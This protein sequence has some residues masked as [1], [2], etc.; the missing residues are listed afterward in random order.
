[1]RQAPAL[2]LLVGLAG[3]PPGV[4]NPTGNHPPLSEAGPEQA[5]FAGAAVTL[6]G[7]ASSDPDGDAL[8]YQWSQTNTPAVTLGGASTSKATFT[9]PPVTAPTT[10]V[11]RLDVSDGHLSNT[12]STAVTV[13]PADPNNHPPTASAIGPATVQAA[14][15]VTLDG[16]ASSDPDGDS[17]TFAWTQT[18]G[19]AVALTGASAS[20]ATFAAPPVTSDTALSFK[21]TVSDGRGGTATATVSMTAQPV[22]SNQPPVA[23]AG[24]DQTVAAGASVTLSGAGTDP[25]GDAI[26]SYAWT[27]T[28]GP[29][30]VLASASAQ[31]PTFTATSPGATVVLNFALVVTDAK[32]LGSAPATARVTV[33][34]QPATAAVFTKVVSLHAVT[35]SSIVVF[36]M[37]DV[38]LRA[39]VDYGKTSTG[40]NTFTEAAASTRHVITLPGLSPDTNYKYTVRAGTAVASGS[41]W[42]AF[43]YQTNPK[44]FSFAVVGDARGHT[45]WATVSNSILAKNPRFAIQSGDNNNDVGSA[46]NWADYYLKGKA[47]FAEV[48]MF[49]AQGNHDTG[50]NYTVYNVAPQSGSGSELY[51]AFVYGNAGFVAIDTNSAVTGLSWVT[52][53]LNKLSGGPLFAFHHHPLYSC[54]SHGSS[55]TMQTL[56][57]S[58][59]ETAKVTVDYTGHDHDLIVWSTVN[60]VRYVVSGGGGTSLY[61]LS[62]CQGPYAKSGYGFM[63]VDVDGQSVTET[64]YDQNG[65]QLW[66]SGA[67]NA[68]GPSVNFANLPGLVIY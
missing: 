32:G 55:T 68:Q 38:S 28:A 66:T 64:M 65:A 12:S 6:D 51:Y 61:G 50:S 27:Q 53:A 10:L 59:F 7:T 21:L 17:L 33:N 39:S 13:N 19:P 20:Q 9:A 52:N 57:K 41:F 8:T 3:C 25:D 34:A 48:P 30:V 49:A 22:S 43:D 42:T 11:F 26:A 63:M 67:F 45:V 15:A 37:T 40:E 54:G 14:A 56:Y 18:A 31:N 2:L 1:M 29:A 44:P 36:F 24:A 16:S 60:G 46:A 47:M 23:N 62:G 5:V 35:R 58:K 4:A